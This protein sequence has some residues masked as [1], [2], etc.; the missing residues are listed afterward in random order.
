MHSPTWGGVGGVI[1]VGGAYHGWK[2]GRLETFDPQNPPAPLEIDAAEIGRRG[3][4]PMMILADRN[5]EIPLTADYDMLACFDD[6][7]SL[8]QW[9]VDDIDAFWRSIWDYFGIRSATPVG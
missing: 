4:R 7:T 6:F 9:S 5:S 2:N 8:W 1:K 3:T